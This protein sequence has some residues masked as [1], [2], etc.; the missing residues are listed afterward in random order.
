MFTG[1]QDYEPFPEEVVFRSA[2]V[3]NFMR[4]FGN[5]DSSQG[6]DFSSQSADSQSSAQSRL[7]RLTTD[8]YVSVAPNNG[9][10]EVNEALFTA[11]TDK[12]KTL[13]TKAESSFALQIEPGDRF[14][15]IPV[16]Q[17]SSKTTGF[18]WSLQTIIDGVCQP[19]KENEDW[20]M[21]KDIQ[22]KS[23]KSGSF[24]DLGKM[25]DCTYFGVRAKPILQYQ[26]PADQSHLMYFNLLIKNYY[27][28]SYKKYV[29]LNSQQSSLNF[30]MQILDIAKPAN[31]DPTY[32]TLFVA[33]EAADFD[34][35]VSYT[36]NKGLRYQALVFMVVGPQIPQ[37]IHIQSDAENL[38]VI[39]QEPV[40]KRYMVEDLGSSSDFDFND[41]VVDVV[42]SGDAR[43]N[44]SRDPISNK[45]SVAIQDPETSATVRH[46]CG[47]RPFQLI[48]GDTQFP[49]VT[50]PTNVAQTLLQLQNTKIENPDFY[51]GAKKVIGWEP[52]VSAVVTG[53][54]PAENNLSVTVWRS[55]PLMDETSGGWQVNFPSTGDV[56]YIMALP[57][58]MRWT[59]EG[60]RFDGWLQFV[61]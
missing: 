54:K 58:N 56:P 57:C 14:E 13:N 46:L 35:N 1:C 29:A 9:Y 47:T 40:S 42:Q 5:V 4:Q 23:T 26:N 39:K 60:Q 15:I 44:I 19:Y 11:I 33:C 36:L 52:D 30:Q 51:E 10:Y 55:N 12:L 43:I 2:Y 32:Q 27:Y 3:R 17:S 45:T 50:D 38:P 53:W 20:P 22:T 34:P 49:C 8:A 61:P 7:T 16:F 25:S 48:V 59:E 31:I 6:W 41:I 18:E 37:V 28:A 24:S 21:G